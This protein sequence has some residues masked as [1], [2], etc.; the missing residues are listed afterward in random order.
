MIILVM[1]V[2]TRAKSAMLRGRTHSGSQSPQVDVESPRNA[3]VAVRQ[4][5][6][7]MLARRS[8][9]KSKSPIGA[10]NAIGS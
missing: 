7:T 5:L 9:R 1:I 8:N 2:G 6:E 10:T 3:A 4:E